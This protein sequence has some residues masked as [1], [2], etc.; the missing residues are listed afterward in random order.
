MGHP[1][2]RVRVLEPIT[3]I[4]KQAP[5]TATTARPWAMWLELMS[6]PTKLKVKRQIIRQ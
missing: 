6:M 1:R 2:R 3:K 5:L 4:Q